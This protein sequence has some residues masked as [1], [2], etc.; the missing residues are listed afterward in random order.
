MDNLFGENAKGVERT[1]AE[2]AV[3]NIPEPENFETA[4]A[5]LEKLVRELESGGLPLQES[6]EVYKKAR[7]TASWCY[8]KLTEIQGELKKLGLDE[9]G[10]F[11]LEDLPPVE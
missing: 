10:G 2:R 4:M 6:V 11:T 5:E 9:E 8:K 3:S 1:D 7:E